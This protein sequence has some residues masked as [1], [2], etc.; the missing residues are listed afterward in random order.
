MTSAIVSVRRVTSARAAGFGVYPSLRMA[1]STA[2]LAAG[3]TR[4]DPLTTRDTVARETPA[5]S[6]TS[7]RVGCA[8]RARA[9]LTA[10][11]L[12]S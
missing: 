2:F 3:L 11:T 6:P 1:R 9:T 12:P 8:S 4:G 7:S 5:T 10:G